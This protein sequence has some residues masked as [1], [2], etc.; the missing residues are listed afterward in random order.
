MKIEL[1]PEMERFVER[2][3]RAGEYSNPGDLVRDAIQVL[4]DQEALTPEQ[5]AYL[6]EE[7]GRGI[8]QAD[9]REYAQFNAESIIAEERLRH[10]ETP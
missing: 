6:R 8:A 9:R 7:V 1:P 10:R 4:M 2:K 3:V 5:A